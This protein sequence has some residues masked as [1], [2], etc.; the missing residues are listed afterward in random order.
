MIK[1]LKLDFFTLPQMKKF[2]IM[3]IIKITIIV[4]IFIH[5]TNKITGDGFVFKI[6]FWQY[7]QR[8]LTLQSSAAIQTT[9]TQMTESKEAVKARDTITL[10]GRQYQQIIFQEKKRQKSFLL[11]D[12]RTICNKD[13]SSSEFL[14]GN[15]L[16]DDVR[17]VKATKY[18]EFISFIQ[19]VENIIIIIINN[20]NQ[21]KKRN[22]INQ[23]V[24]SN[25]NNT[26]KSLDC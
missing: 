24:S 22:F 1:K 7:L 9:R 6:K 8:Q 14:L 3:I 20:D 5:M 12:Y 19:K 10:L 23:A 18:T 25:R 11:E 21:C 16:A 15:G 17:K 2:G 13:H 4:T 26:K